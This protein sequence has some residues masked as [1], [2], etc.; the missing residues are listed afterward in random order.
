MRKN[1]L[2]LIVLVLV[3]IVLSA[4]QLLPEE[5]VLPPIPVIRSYEV[6][7]YEQVTVMRGDLVSTATVRLTYKLT[8]KQ[9]LSFSLGGLYIDAV[10]VV[11]SV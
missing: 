11:P 10:P 6:E 2:R 8:R 9:S 7:E 1:V 5:E 3:S 4:C